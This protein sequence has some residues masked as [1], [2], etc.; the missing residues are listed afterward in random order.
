MRVAGRPRD[1]RYTSRTVSDYCDAFASLAIRNSRAL[2]RVCH[3]GPEFWRAGDGHRRRR[4]LNP[5]GGNAHVQD[6][7]VTYDP[8]RWG[9]YGER[10]N[11]YLLLRPE[12]R[13]AHARAEH[14]PTRQALVDANRRMGPT[15]TTAPPPAPTTAPKIATLET[16]RRVDF[17]GEAPMLFGDGMRKAPFA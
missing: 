11:K 5:S 12:G 17:T 14:L 13:D 1:H 7:Q 16:P 3:N 9:R 10:G 15:A 8:G 6:K 2:R 4:R